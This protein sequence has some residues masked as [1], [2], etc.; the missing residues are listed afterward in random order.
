MKRLTEK[1][2]SLKSQAQKRVQN[3]LE[4]ALGLCET[5]IDDLRPKQQHV[6]QSVPVEEPCQATK[7]TKA[8]IE[9]LEEAAKKLGIFEIEENQSQKPKEPQKLKPVP[10]MVFHKK[11]D[12]A[13]QQ[14]E[15]NDIQRARQAARQLIEE[16]RKLAQ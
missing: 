12:A 1:L 10:D 8:E 11:S 14:A 15:Q 6:P 13:L 9:S 7:K 4:L 2:Q 5:V 3:V 16:Q